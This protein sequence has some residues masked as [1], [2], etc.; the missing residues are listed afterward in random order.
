MPPYQ[1]GVMRKPKRD[2][3]TERGFNSRQEWL[4]SRMEQYRKKTSKPCLHCAESCWGNRVYCSNKCTV[5]DGIEKTK[6]GCWEWIKSKNPAGYGIF[7]N[8]DDRTQKPG[9]KMR[10]ML[11]HRASYILHKG[12]IPDG[13]FVCHS[14]DNRA[15][16]NPDHLFLGSAKDN[17]RDALR[18]GKLAVHNLTYRPPKGKSFNAKLT[19]SDVE[20]I[21]RR[22]SEN[23]RVVEIAEDYFVTPQCIY[24]IKHGKTWRE[25]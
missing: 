24:S 7:K 11:A 23:H 22:I 5:L 15:C 1:G 2:Y 4:N 25:V 20:E 10:G 3:W 12:K 17:A 9:N 18:K 8:L 21:K 13:K 16:C 14:C 6:S 19:I